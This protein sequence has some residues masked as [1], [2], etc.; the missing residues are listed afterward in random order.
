MKMM[1]SNSTANRA[2]RARA[3]TPRAESRR[4]TRGREEQRPERRPKIIRPTTAG[5][6][7]QQSPAGEMV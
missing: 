1:D 5:P 3:H 2:P 6:N 4:E 7:K